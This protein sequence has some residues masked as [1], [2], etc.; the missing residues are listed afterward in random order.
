MATH[1]I[2]LEAEGAPDGPI[3]LIDASLSAAELANPRRLGGLARVLRFRADPE[4]AVEARLRARAIDP[5]RVTD[6]VLT[7]LDLDHAGGLADFPEARVHVHPTELAAA[8]RR[9]TFGERLRYRPEQFGEARFAEVAE[10]PSE[11]APGV[12]GIALD[13][14]APFGGDAVALV[15]LFG[16]TRG[17]CGVLVT[18]ADPPL[19]HVG[20]AYYARTERTQPPSWAFSMF[21]RSVHVDA[22][23]ASRSL[24]RIA[25]LEGSLSGL[26]VVS[27]H[28]PTEFP[29]P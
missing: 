11:V 16:H 12:E 15:P 25:E 22:R 7:H 17:H 3:I 29:T 27:T 28:D 6:I 26:R 23:E 19:L 13:L 2:A 4:R 10:E 20:D 21:R 8:R 24:G 18:G 9:R 5:R 14:P 1:V